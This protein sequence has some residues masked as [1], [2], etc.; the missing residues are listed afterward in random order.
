MSSKG[1][2][3]HA[4]LVVS[5]AGPASVTLYDQ[6]NSDDGIGIVSDTFD[7]GSFPTY[8]NAAADD[9]TVVA[10]KLWKVKEVDV[11]GVYFNGSGPAD[12]VHVNFYADAGGLPGATLATC[13]PASY[14]DS[15]GFGSFVIKLGKSC[16]GSTKFKNKSHVWVSV[17]ADMNFVGGKGEWGW[18]NRTTDSGSP[19]AWEN[20]GNGFGTGCVTWA[21][22]NVCIADGQG[23]HM[24]ILKGVSK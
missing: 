16:T 12:A 18:E 11:T 19:A 14:K 20:P 6:N 17:V 15:S 5:G 4:Q 8:S 21:Q 24:F 2:P 9:F 13:N 22:E 7:S 1:S 23:D 3:H 10:P